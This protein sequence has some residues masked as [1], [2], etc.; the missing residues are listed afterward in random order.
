MDLSLPGTS[1]VDATAQIRRRL[2]QQKVLALSEYGSEINASEALRAGCRFI[3]QRTSC[4]RQ[5]AP[6]TRRRNSSRVAR[7]RRRR[8]TSKRYSLGKPKSEAM[9]STSSRLF[10]RFRPNGSW[11]LRPH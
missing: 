3:S 11:R 6:F 1:G 2:P 5:R 8:S 4:Q 7:P 10:K 9:W